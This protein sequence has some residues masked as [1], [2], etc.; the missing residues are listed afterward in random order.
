VVG[1]GVC[2]GAYQFTVRTV[3]QRIRQILLVEP[4]SCEPGDAAGTEMERSGAG[5]R[6]AAAQCARRVRA[7]KIRRV[8]DG[9]MPQAVGKRVI[10]SRRKQE[11]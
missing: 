1:G 5:A 11:P 10:E 9:R 6:C 3:V 7:S 8:Q 2:E 4:P